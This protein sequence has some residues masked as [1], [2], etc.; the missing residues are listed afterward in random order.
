[1]HCNLM[2]LDVAPVVLNC[3]WLNLYGTSA[4]TAISQLR[5]HLTSSFDLATRFPKREH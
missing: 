3:F 1:M 2:T 4:P 5:S